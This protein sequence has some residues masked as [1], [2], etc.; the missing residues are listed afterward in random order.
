M[1]LGPVGGDGR[2]GP[3]PEDAVRAAVASLAAADSQQ[4][5]LAALD[6]VDTALRALR[7]AVDR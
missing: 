3:L 7:D 2:P 1:G 4:G 5:V 6:G